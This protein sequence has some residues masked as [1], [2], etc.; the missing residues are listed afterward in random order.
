MVLT[1][2]ASY[3]FSLALQNPADFS[4]QASRIDLSH[5][6]F[7]DIQH[8]CSTTWKANTKRRQLLAY[9]KEH[10]EE[11]AKHLDIPVKAREITTPQYPPESLPIGTKRIPTKWTQDAHT[12]AASDSGRTN[13]SATTSTSWNKTGGTM[14]FTTCGPISVHLETVFIAISFTTFTLSGVNM[15]SDS[16]D[17]SGFASYAH[18]SIIPKFPFWNICEM[19]MAMRY[20]KTQGNWCWKCLN[21]RYLL[22]SN[23]PS[24]R[25]L[26]QIRRD[27]RSTWP[28]IF[29]N[30][31]SFVLP[32][33]KSEETKHASLEGGLDDPQRAL[34]S[35]QEQPGSS[36]S[37]ASEKS[38]PVEKGQALSESPDLD[39]HR[40]V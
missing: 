34:I 2:V 7:H 14:Y 40:E 8:A 23:V 31:P 12:N 10:V 4:S 33:L 11:I 28:G 29:D 6:D 38:L 36:K 39:H 17:E 1:V 30:Y 18:A 20:Q 3:K 15:N 21:G 9:H 13:F 32:R 37:A 35:E 24:V 19:R 16:I 27:S 25:N 5:F 22:R 26:Y